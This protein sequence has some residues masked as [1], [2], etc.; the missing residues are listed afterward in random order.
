MSGIT[1]SSQTK[2]AGPALRC[3][4]CRRLHH[5]PAPGGLPVHCECGW[6]YRNVRGKIIDEFRPRLAGR[7]Y[8]A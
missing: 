4:R 8:P 6:T 1:Y 2:I 7:G 5:H 3:T